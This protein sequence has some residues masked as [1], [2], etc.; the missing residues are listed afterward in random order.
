M[1]RICAQM[2]QFWRFTN[3]MMRY[4]VGLTVADRSLTRN[5]L[6]FVGDWNAHSGLQCPRPRRSAE[7]RGWLEGGRAMSLTPSIV[8]ARRN[9]G[10]EVRLTSLIT[11]RLKCAY[12]G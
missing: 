3:Q 9:T 11:D 1:G 12:S 8:A 4:K 10:H 5:W 6:A 2:F 7:Q